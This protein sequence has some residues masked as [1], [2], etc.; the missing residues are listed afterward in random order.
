[1]LVET[2][3]ERKSK[4]KRK[5][6]DHRLA[7]Q[8]ELLHLLDSLLCGI[9]RVERDERLS[10]H[11]Q[12]PVGRYAENVSVLLEEDLEGLLHDCG[13]ST[14]QPGRLGAKGGRD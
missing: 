9:L 3:V 11:P 7:V 12:I 8:R 10:S 13:W 5:E 14:G 6:T 1:M 2:E 4:V